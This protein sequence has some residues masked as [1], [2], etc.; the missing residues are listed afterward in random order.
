MLMGLVTL[1]P[2]QQA[3]RGENLMGGTGN[4]AIVEREARLSKK[5]GF[6]LMS[7]D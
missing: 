6:K 3:L 4:D 2:E 1:V 5:L 7:Q